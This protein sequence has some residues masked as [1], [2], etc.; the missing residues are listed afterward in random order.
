MELCYVSSSLSLCLFVLQAPFLPPKPIQPPIVV[1][2]QQLDEDIRTL[3]Q[4]QQI[5][6]VIFLAQGVC[7]PAHKV[8]LVAASPVFEELFLADWSMADELCHGDNDDVICENIKNGN[9]NSNGNHSN[10]G[11]CGHGGRN[12]GSSRSNSLKK[13]HASK[14]KEKSTKAAVS[15]TVKLLEYE[16][17][18]TSSVETL[19]DPRLAPGDSNVTRRRILLN[20]PAFSCIE[21][22]QVDDAFNR[23]E[24][25]IQ[26]RKSVV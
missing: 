10:H 3:L 21:F 24:K 15:D 26:D 4:N 22:E 8:C 14:E 19:A 20:L 12:A 6:D 11:N 18:E 1:P 16:E 25:N 23:G 2:E 17:M 5:C 13:T 7:I 9:A